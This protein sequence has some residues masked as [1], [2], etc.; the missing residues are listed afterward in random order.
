[1]H[2]ISTVIIA[3]NEEECIKD[4]IQSCLAFADEVV[5]IDGGSHDATIQIAQDLGCKVYTNTWPGYAKQRNFG[6]EKAVNE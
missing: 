6:A 5:V 1:M 4:A 3:Q 2:N